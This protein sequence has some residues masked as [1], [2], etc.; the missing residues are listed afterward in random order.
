MTMIKIVTDSSCMLESQLIKDLNIHII[1]LS[2]MIDDVIYED[3]ESF[4]GEQFVTLMQE[5]QEL[6]KTSQPSIGKFIDIYD[7]LGAD[8]SSIISIHMTESLSG[9]VNAARQAS[10][11]S[12]SNVWVVDSLFTDQALAFQVIKAAE[13]AKD[14]KTVE[15]ILSAIN[16]VK[17]HTKLY[18]GIS[19]LENL[20]KGGR[21]HR[22]V[23]MLSNI[24][25]MR[26]MLEF[27]GGELLVQS[28]GRGAKTFTKWFHLFKEELIQVSKK[29]EIKRIGISYA[30]DV[31]LPIQFKQELEQLFPQINVSLLYT[32]PIV[33]THSGLDAFA[34]MYYIS[35]C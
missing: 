21:V 32:S 28:K 26:V 19:T 1:P 31:S 9:T 22:V 4:S 8:G 24:F 27:K 33:S 2:V 29:A 10:E 16:D 35:E 25:N 34:V 18:M 3:D 20:V 6:P 12:Q 15:E 5:S 7:Q 11:L 13:L 30:G 23:G 14:N 17:E